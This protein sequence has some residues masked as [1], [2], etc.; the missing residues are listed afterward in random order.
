MM[1][2]IRLLA[3]VFILV[4]V[5]GCAEMPRYDD[6]K[7]HSNNVYVNPSADKAIVYFYAT[8][9]WRQTLYYM[10]DSDKKIG[11]I[12]SGCYFFYEAEPGAHFFWAETEARSNVYFDV[13]AGKTYYIDCRTSLGMWVMTP[14]IERVTEKIGSSEIKNLKYCTT[15]R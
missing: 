9:D 10:W 11:A 3:I 13:E 2:Y 6:F 5:S 15:I 12:R 4:S 7:I 14:N 1:F 8:E